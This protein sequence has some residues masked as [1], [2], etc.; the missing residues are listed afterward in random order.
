MTLLSSCIQNSLPQLT[1]ELGHTKHLPW[2]LAADAKLPA[3]DRHGP[4]PGSLL[5]AH[6]VATHA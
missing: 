5:I 6:M 3:E 2:G 4:S 1:S